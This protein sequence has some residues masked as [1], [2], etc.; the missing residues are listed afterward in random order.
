MS[1]VELSWAA[2]FAE[3]AHDVLRRIDRSPSVSSELNRSAASPTAWQMAQEA[4]WTSV[5]LSERLGGLGLGLTELASIHRVAG[6]HLFPGPLVES[7]T[8]AA[9]LAQRAGDERLA[10]RLV[11][12]EIIALA[13]PAAA[14]GEL[15][16]RDDRLR[17]SVRAARYAAEAKLVL[18]VAL[19]DTGENVV[20]VI[21][22]QHPG[23]Q[24]TRLAALDPTTQLCEIQLDCSLPPDLRIKLEEPERS[25]AIARDRTRIMLACERL[26]IAAHCL[27]LAV[28]YAKE[29]EQFGE[30]IG[31]FQAIQHILADSARRTFTLERLCGDIAAVADDLVNAELGTE[32]ATVDAFS[33]VV[34]RQVVEQ[35]LQVHGG[36]AFTVEHPLHLY[37]KR[38]LTLEGLWGE[39]GDQCTALGQALLTSDMDPWGS[40]T[41]VRDGERP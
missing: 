9:T 27:S 4:G 1:A 14:G 26:G 2:E 5:L 25:V 16:F 15:T 23:L 6:E 22:R 39:P 24:I 3:A 32:A 19:T 37:Y 11:A 12:S 17:G 38:L 13:D 41:P 20:A 33:A 21:P 7:S 10:A 29:R 35:S 36:I 31:A 40:R 18:A 34:A 28:A 30:P 8:F